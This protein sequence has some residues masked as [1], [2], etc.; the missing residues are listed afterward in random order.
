MTGSYQQAN[1]VEFEKFVDDWA[2]DIKTRC[3][4]GE[5]FKNGDRSLNEIEAYCTSLDDEVIREYNTQQEL[6]DVQLDHIKDLCKDALND[7]SD[8]HE[9]EHFCEWVRKSMVEDQI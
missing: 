6:V 5:I 9:T 8:E 7:Q 2:L 4:N 1:Q 3:M